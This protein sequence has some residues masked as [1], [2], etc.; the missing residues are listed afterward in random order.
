MEEY[1]TI[2]DLRQASSLEWGNDD[3]ITR[4]D[5]AGQHSYNPIFNR[6]PLT[7]ESK[8]LKVKWLADREQKR[9][10]IGYTIV[11][12]IVVGLLGILL[13]ANHEMC[14]LE[15]SPELCITN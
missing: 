10:A 7:V 3:E 13:K 12:F 4:D 6:P 14:V 9:A 11:L 5:E 2:R 15:G 8:A 1:R